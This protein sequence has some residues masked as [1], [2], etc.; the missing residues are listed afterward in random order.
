MV[1][2]SPLPPREPPPENAILNYRGF[3]AKDVMQAPA[4]PYLPHFR[5]TEEV[6]P[7]TDIDFSQFRADP[8]SV[9]RKYEARTKK[10][11]GEKDTVL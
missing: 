5:C 2:S 1:H 9:A 4:Y 8:Y 7:F 3:Q 10:R 11:E 6:Q